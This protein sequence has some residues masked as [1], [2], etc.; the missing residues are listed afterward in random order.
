MSNIDRARLVNSIVFFAQNTN[1]CGKT[2]LFKLLYLLDFSHYSKTGKSVTGSE[3][4]AWQLG[5]VPASLMAEWT[6]FEQDLAESIRVERERF[7]DG[8]I[9][10]SVR[11]NAGIVF[12]DSDFTPRQIAIMRDLAARYRDANA[13]DMVDVTHSPDGAWHQIWDNGAGK[14]SRIPYGLAEPEDHQTREY[15]Q[16]SARNAQRLPDQALPAT[17]Y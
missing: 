6:E 15:I 9:R 4:Q 8:T 17:D 14:F 7:P 12:D 10:D 5:P 1:I 11:V 13:N 2:K 3:Y 16:D